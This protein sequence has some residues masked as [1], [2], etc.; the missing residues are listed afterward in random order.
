MLFVG[1]FDKK[2]ENTIFSILSLLNPIFTQYNPHLVNI[3]KSGV[4]KATQV[5]PDLL[6]KGAQVLDH[7]VFKNGQDVEF[8]NF[9]WGIYL[10]HS[11]RFYPRS[12]IEVIALQIESKTFLFLNASQGIMYIFSYSKYSRTAYNR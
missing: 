11:T 6:P 9:I 5:I 3:F 10:L 12:D 2:G 4:L 7:P 8:I 1:K